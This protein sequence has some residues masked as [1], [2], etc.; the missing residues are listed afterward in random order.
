MTKIDKFPL[1]AILTG[2]IAPLGE[3]NVPSG[4]KKS[5]VKGPL[6][7][8]ASGFTGDHQADTRVHGGPEKA[9]HHYPRDH[10]AAWKREIGDHPL[11][12]SPGAFGENLST[13]GLNEETVALGDV[14]RLG[15]AVVEVSQGRQPCWKLNSRFGV[16]TMAYQVQKTGRTG[17]YYRVLQEG[18]VSS[19]DQL[20]RIERPLPAWPLKRLW[21]ILYVKTLDRGELAEMAALSK[22]PDGWRRYAQRR[23]ASGRV[24]DWSRRLEGEKQ[25]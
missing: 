1:E 7:L 11:L 20:E 17:W 16:G 25:D 12:A 19:E 10:Y 6:W 9:V 3:R 24:E 13:F 4:I 2:N 8:G 18:M 21:Q 23:L 22:L 14:F 15:E 5:A